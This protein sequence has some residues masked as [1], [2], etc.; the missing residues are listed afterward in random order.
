MK[1][2][3]ASIFGV[4]FDDYIGEDGV[5]APGGGAPDASGDGSNAGYRGYESGSKGDAGLGDLRAKFE[6]DRR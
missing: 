1:G 4:A 5:R 3:G 6:E 2:G